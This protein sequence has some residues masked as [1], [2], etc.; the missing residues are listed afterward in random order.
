MRVGLILGLMVLFLFST[1]ASPRRFYES[2]T[3]FDFLG[4]IMRLLPPVSIIAPETN[5]P[6]RADGISLFRFRNFRCAERCLGGKK[7]AYP[8]TKG[9]KLE[10]EEAV[11][12]H[13]IC[14]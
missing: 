5:I 14:F 6:I 9:S 12:G 10:K 11:F 3:W 7:L 8:G 13:M 4:F 2:A 1:I